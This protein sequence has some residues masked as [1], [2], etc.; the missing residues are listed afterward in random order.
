MH[1]F[2]D[3]GIVQSTLQRLMK[4]SGSRPWSRFFPGSP[5]R[6]KLATHTCYQEM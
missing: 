3:L 5:A 1:T 2:D 6:K 4:R